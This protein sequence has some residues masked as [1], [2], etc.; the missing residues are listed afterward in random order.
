[1]VIYPGKVSVADTFR[2]GT[3]GQV[4]PDDVQRLLRAIGAA[5]Y[6]HPENDDTVSGLSD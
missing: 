1:F 2:I 5:C 6:W 4:F 3:I